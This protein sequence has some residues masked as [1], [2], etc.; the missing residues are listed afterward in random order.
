VGL[1]PSLLFILGSTCILLCSNGGNLLVFSKAAVIVS[2]NLTY[3]VA[4]FVSCSLP[5]VSCQYR[6]NDR[7]ETD[8]W[9]RRISRTGTRLRY[10]RKDKAATSYRVSDSRSREHDIL[11]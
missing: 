4:V 6:V 2:R 9:A 1:V 10:S 11:L 3:R 5:A 8:T 7:S